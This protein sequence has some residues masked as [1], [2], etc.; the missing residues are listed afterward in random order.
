MTKRRSIFTA[1]AAAG[2]LLVAGTSFARQRSLNKTLLEDTQVS[3]TTYAV[4][5]L[6]NVD[7][8]SIQAINTAGVSLSSNTFEDGVKATGTVTIAADYGKL[9]LSTGTGSVTVVDYTALRLTAATNTVTV[10]DYTALTSLAASP[11]VSTITYGSPTAGTVSFNNL[12]TDGTSTFTYTASLPGANEFNDIG[13]LTLLINGLTD[14]NASNDGTDITIVVVTSGTAMNSATVTGTGDY[15]GVSITFS[16][17]RN[18]AT[19]T[20]NGTVLT[21]G[22]EWTASVSS[23]TTGASLSG[24]INAL[25]VVSSTHNAYGVIYATASTAG[26][27]G[28]AITLASSDA[29]NLALGGATFSGG[30]DAAT[31]TIGTVTLTES[32]DFD[33]V[34]S[35]ITTAGNLKTAIDALPLVSATDNGDG[36]VTITAASAGAAGNLALASSDAVNL[37]LSGAAMTGGQDAATFTIGGNVL[38]ESTDFDA[39][40]SSA[41]TATSLASAIDALSILGASASVNVVYATATFPG[42]IGHY[43]M[44][45]SSPSY[46]TASAANMSGGVNPDVSTTTSYITTN[47][48]HGWTNGTALLFTTVTGT[49]PTGLTTGTTYYAIYVDSDTIQLATTVSNAD[50]GTNI[51]ITSLTGSGSFGLT[52]LTWGSNTVKLQASIDGV[53]YNDISGTETTLTAAGSTLWNVVDPFYRYLRFV[54]TPVAGATGL[55]VYINGK[56]D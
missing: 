19:V 10:V 1:I 4:Q 2:L 9:H 31:V 3:E 5:N 45:S 37:A 55:T 56:S 50:A 38:T 22:T 28:N 30:I 48:G 47:S 39:I 49:A 23:G 42:T 36:S 6:D 51:S 17:G 26:T 40:T 16:G 43:A 34:T 44:V 21:Q 8:V 54:Y 12:P 25:A 52:T 13:D 24:A 15:S 46:M 53:N 11:S 18:N 41:A 29:V 14:L 35:S 32:T 27:S 20:V 33:A 7:G